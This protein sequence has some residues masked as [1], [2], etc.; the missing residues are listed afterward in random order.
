MEKLFIVEFGLTYE[1]STVVRT[2]RKY[3]TARDWALE[4]WADAEAYD[5][6]RIVE[7]EL[8]NGKPFSDSEYEELEETVFEI[9][10]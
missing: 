4:N 2:F 8:D 10:G 9:K 3:E 7:R 1:D 5:W 6:C